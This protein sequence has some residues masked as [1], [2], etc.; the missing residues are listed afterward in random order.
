MV[1]NSATSLRAVDDTMSTVLDLER[2]A[3]RLGAIVHGVDLVETADGDSH[4]LVDAIDDALVEHK[5]LFFRG[6]HLDP[7]THVRFARRFGPVTTA[8]PT[9]PSVPGHPHVFELDAAKGARANVWH[10]DVT[11]LD[12]PP[13]ASI[14]N[15]VVIPPVGGDTLWADTEAAYAGLPEHLKAVV[16]RAWAVHTNTADYGELTSAKDS[17]TAAFRSAHYEARHPV[18]RIHPRSG[19]PTLLLGGFV[20]RIEGLSSQESHDL[21][22]LVQSHVTRPENTVRWRWQQGDVVMWDNCATQ[23]YAIDDFG[24]APRRVQ[25]VTLVGEVARSLDGQA[26]E[27]M[28]GDADSYLALG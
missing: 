12:R 16:D 4:E 23:H 28:H 14:L 19:R 22:R 25:R 18:V 24:D 26:S 9:V 21:V 17:Y 6:Q 5:V 27:L 13:R 10:T 3:G 2:V 7:V 1:G 15:G 20:R 11:F 8:H